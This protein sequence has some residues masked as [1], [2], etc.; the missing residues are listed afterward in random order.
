MYGMRGLQPTIARGD[1][2]RHWTI[3]TAAT[4]LAFG[5][6]ACADWDNPTALADLNPDIEI[7]IEADRVETYE[8]VEIHVRAS[9]SGMPMTMRQ[10]Q[11]AIAHH[12]GGSAQLVDLAPQGD[13]WAAHVRFFEPGEHHVQFHGLLRGHQ[14]MHEFGETEVEAFRMHRIIGPYWLEIEMN[15][16][17]VLPGGQAHIHLHAFTMGPDGLPDLPAPGLDMHLEMHGVGGGETALDINEEA[18]GEYET[19]YSFT[20]AGL[21]ELHVEIDISGVHADGEFQLPILDPA[22]DDDEQEGEDDGHGHSH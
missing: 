14:L 20:T 1:T 2:M 10:A 3:Y 7:D 18:T 17:R 15:P 13:G 9:E 11:L 21:Y 12:D 16:G 8:E 19:A 22:A 6:A 5:G 4:A